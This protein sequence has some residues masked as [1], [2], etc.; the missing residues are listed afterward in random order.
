MHDESPDWVE[1]PARPTDSPGNGRVA[2]KVNEGTVDRA[3]RV[4][5]GIGLLA[6]GVF[7]VKGTIGIV[8]DVLG[9]V[10]L[11]TGLV[12]FCALYSLF[13]ISTAKGK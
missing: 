8:L 6:L 1:E 7:V 4:V 3:V 13:G 2:M 12:G 5:V 11:A 10:L 9:V